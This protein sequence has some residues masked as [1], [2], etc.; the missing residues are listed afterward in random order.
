[1]A[2]LFLQIYYINLIFKMHYIFIDMNILNHYCEINKFAQYCERL[3]SLCANFAFKNKGELTRKKHFPRSYT[4][5]FVFQFFNATSPGKLNCSA[6]HPEMDSTKSKDASYVEKAIARFLLASFS[7]SKVHSKFLR[8]RTRSE[9][10]GRMQERSARWKMTILACLRVSRGLEHVE[11]SK[12]EI[13]N[14]IRQ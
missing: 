3:D 11:N 1:M 13:D 10:D 8:E 5:G 4:L 9:D 2:N 14:T 7:Q 12:R 6:D